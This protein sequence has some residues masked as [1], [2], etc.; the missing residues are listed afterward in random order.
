MQHAHKLSQFFGTLPPFLFCILV[1]LASR[2]A[3]PNA[4]RPAPPTIARACAGCHSL[5]DK[6]HGSIPSISGRPEAEFVGIM[7]AYQSG[8]R[9]SSIMNRIAKGYTEQDFINLARYLH[10]Q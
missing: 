2:A 5:T 6:A 4:E 3:E 1:S 8:Q 7:Q 10:E 9:Q